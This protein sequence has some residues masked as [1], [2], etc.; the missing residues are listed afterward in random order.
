MAASGAADGS[1]LV[2]N[3]NAGW[4]KRKGAPI[5]YHRRFEI[6]YDV[7]SGEY[8]MLDRFQ[9]ENVTATDA[10]DRGIKKKAGGTANPA[11]MKSVGWPPQCAIHKVAWN[12][13]NGLESAGW[14]ASGTA[15]GLVRV[16]W[17]A[18]RFQGDTAPERMYNPL[19]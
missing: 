1:V 14:L 12:S 2:A 8:R 19:G 3:F 16:E 4:H 18:G 17:V 13:A 15:S 6:D 5:I 11:L 7:E 9:V 10:A